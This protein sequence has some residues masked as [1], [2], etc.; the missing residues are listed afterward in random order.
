MTNSRV[1]RNTHRWLPVERTFFGY[2]A[3]PG[4]S[5][6]SSAYFTRWPKS[7][8]SCHGHRATRLVL[9]V[10]DHREDR[11]ERGRS[12]WLGNACGSVHGRV[13]PRRQIVGRPCPGPRCRC[14]VGRRFRPGSQPTTQAETAR[15][16]LPAL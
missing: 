2:A 12:L 9:V 3:S 4:V 11:E 1:E 15:R 16:H 5:A 8:P 10:S 13:L 6:V 7:T 14:A